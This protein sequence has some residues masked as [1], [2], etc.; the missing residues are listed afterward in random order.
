M[1]KVIS[2]IKT[3]I[4]HIGDNVVLV[5]ISGMGKFLFLMDCILAPSCL[6]SDPL[7][8]V[9]KGGV[10]LFASICIAAIFPTPSLPGYP[11]VV[12]RCVLLST[13]LKLIDKA[14]VNSCA[15]QQSSTPGW[16]LRFL[17]FSVSLCLNVFLV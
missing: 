1:A 5:V 15:R 16:I 6:V 2:N 13:P 14:F 3:I 7:T 17:C 10:F 8:F 11:G 12:W 4:T 9:G